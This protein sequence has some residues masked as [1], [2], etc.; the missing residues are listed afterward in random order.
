MTNTNSDEGLKRVIGIPGLTLTIISGVIGAGIFVLPSTV[1]SALGAFGIFAYIVCGVLFA[2]ILLCYAEVGSRIT[3]SGGSY[4]YVEAAFGNLPGY[5][6]NWLYFF[7]WGILGSAALMNIVADSLAVLFPVFTNPLVRGILFFCL[8]F[9]MIL[10]NVSGAKQSVGVLKAITIIKLLP[11]LGIIIFGFGYVKTSNLHWEHLPSI[12]SFSDTSLIL[13][14]AFAGFETSLGASGEIKNPKRSVPLSIFI[15]GVVV[16]IVYILLQIVAQGVLGTQMALFK[17]APLAAVAEKIIGLTGATILLLCAAL[18]CF[19]NVTLDILCTPRSLFAGA[20]DGLFPKFVS[21][22]HPKFAT[23]YIAII[24]YGVLIFIFSITGGFQQLA[25]MASAIIL[26]IYL[27]VILATIKLRNNIIAGD[28]NYFKAPGGLITP[29]IAIAAIIWLL[30][31]LGKWEVLST[32][33]FIAA[34]IIIYFITKWLKRK[35]ELMK[36]AK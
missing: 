7:G 31:S 19:G 21:K 35:D 16:L 2:T 23:P 17:D 32:L 10:L 27:A 25:I 28:E 34:I 15:A 30:T 24:I 6:I 36:I 4:A 1:G 13:F 18:S 8:I 3:T 14:F 33:I 29:V 11:L 22:V 12:K 9:F 20:K 5:I 26:L